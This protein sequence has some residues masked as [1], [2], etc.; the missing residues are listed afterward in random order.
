MTQATTLEAQTAPTPPIVGRMA[1]DVGEIDPFVTV[2]RDSRAILEK[3]LERCRRGEWALGLRD[4]IRAAEGRRR[5]G[6]MPSL[7]YSYLGYAMAVQERRVKEGLRLCRHAV[8]AEFFQPDNYLNLARTC[9]LAKRRREASQAVA[10]GLAIAADHPELLALQ[11][12]LG[13][14][15][16]PVVR[17]LHRR[18]PVNKLLGRI[19]SGLGGRA[20]T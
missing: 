5:L 20:K 10:R 6:Q 9:L 2:S 3:G 4:L 1:S 17:S 13:N 12:K 15:R 16:L 18:N 11:E 7:Y 8:K 14:R 19:R